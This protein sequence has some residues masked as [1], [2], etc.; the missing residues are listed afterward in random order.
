MEAA[1]VPLADVTMPA[2]VLGGAEMQK[3]QFLLGSCANGR[4]I[5]GW[6]VGI[7]VVIVSRTVAVA[8]M[9]EDL[10]VL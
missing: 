6:L 3:P 5:V 10:R 7:V 1:N 8:F 2:M 9:G 4:Q